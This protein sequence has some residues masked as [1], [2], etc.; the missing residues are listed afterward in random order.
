MIFTLLLFLNFVLKLNTVVWLNQKQTFGCS[1]FSH[2]E[3]DINVGAMINMGCEEDQFQQNYP[4]LVPF[5]MAIDEINENEHLMGNLTLGFT[6]FNGCRFGS[7]QMLL[8]TLPDTGPQYD[9]T[10]CLEG[11]TYPVWFDVVGMIAASFSRESVEL[12]HLAK[13]TTM[14]LFSSAEATSDELSDKARHPTFFRTVSGDSKQ[15]DF[16]LS[17]LEAMNWVYINVVYTEGPYGE[18]AAKQISL[19]SKQKGICIEVLHMVTDRQDSIL[20]EAIQRLLRHKKARVVV[21][22]FEFAGVEFEQVLK[23]LGVDK[24]FI[25]LGS[26][27][28][29]FTIDGVFR[30]KPIRAINETYLPKMSEFF[31]QRDPK[32]ESQDPWLRHIFSDIKNCSWTEDTRDML[33][34][35]CDEMDSEGPLFP[36]TPTAN[37]KYTKMYDIVYLFAKAIDKLLQDDCRFVNIDDKTTLRSCVK[38]GNLVKN[39]KFVEIDGTVNIKIDENG[40][41][42]AKWNMYQTQH[43]DGNIEEVLTATYDELGKPKLVIFWDTIDWSVFKNFSQ[44]NLNL[45]DKNITTPESVCSKPCQP[46]EYRIQQELPCCW[47]CRK[48]L[49][50][51]YI[52]NGTL[53]ELCPFGQWPDEDYAEYCVT[54]EK[55]YLKLGD[56]VTLFLLGV[57]VIGLAFTIYTSGFYIANRERKILKATTR[58]LCAIIISGIFTAYVSVVFYITIPSFWSCMANRHGFNSAVALIYSPLLVKT[59]RIYRIFK[60]TKSG[61]GGAKFIDTRTQIIASILLL[62]IQV[63]IV[64]FLFQLHLS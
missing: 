17:F 42:Y 3:G 57:T 7:K 25:F 63:I 36:F 4:L 11:Q 38:G 33:T 51:E 8:L 27:T 29:Y 58:E 47:D 16:M 23:R 43:R 21:G 20:E 9:E 5:I 6:V 44:Q 18:N 53:C 40:D 24:E 37:A 12:S 50:N 54:I 34:K 39:L 62:L 55:T 59:N 61:I 14:P 19:K 46:R 64:L 1:F 2:Q 22:F 48:C 49:V 10:Y 26:D 30:V 31:E 45:S 56:W 13:L 35:L 41:A 28:V 15:V 52:I 32:I 60:A